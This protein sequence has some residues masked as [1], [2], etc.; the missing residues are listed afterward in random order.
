MAKS[1]GGVRSSGKIE[2]KDLHAPERAEFKAYGDEWDKTYFDD[3]TGGYIVTHNERIASA[4]ASPNEQDKFAKEQDMARDLAKQGY[5][6]EHLSEQNRPKGETY[7]VHLDGESADFKSTSGAGNIQGYAKYAV[8]VQGAKTVVF[9]LEKHKPKM[10]KA[11]Q[12]AK[13]HSGG[14]ILYYYSDDKDLREV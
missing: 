1:Y 14:R 12:D 4:Q 6:I 13:R 7:D 10:M 8:N 11:L 5:K 2:S 3:K 9:R